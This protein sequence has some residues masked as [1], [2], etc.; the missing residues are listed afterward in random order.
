M[1]TICLISHFAYKNMYGSAKNIKRRTINYALRLLLN[2]PKNVP[3]KIL[4]ISFV[5]LILVVIYSL[6]KSS[7]ILIFADLL[8]LIYLIFRAKEL[9]KSINIIFKNYKVS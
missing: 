7:M 5:F 9:N 8:I 1:S 6:F 3:I 4:I 2:Q